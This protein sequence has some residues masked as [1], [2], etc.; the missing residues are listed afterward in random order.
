MLKGRQFDQSVILLCVRWYPRRGEGMT[1]AY[2]KG[3][4]INPIGLIS[5]QYARPFTAEP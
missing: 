1:H 2:Q 3:S 5:M 4:V